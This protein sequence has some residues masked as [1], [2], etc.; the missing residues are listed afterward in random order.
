MP[1]IQ[2]HVYGLVVIAAQRQQCGAAAKVL[3]MHL[4]LPKTMRCKSLYGSCNIAVLP[5]CGVSVVKWHKM[6]L[7]SINSQCI[8]FF[9]L[10]LC[11]CFNCATVLLKNTEILQALCYFTLQ[12]CF[13]FI[14][15]HFVFF[16]F[17]QYLFIVHPAAP[18]GMLH[19]H[20]HTQIY[21]YVC[22]HW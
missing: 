4:L 22:I 20:S 12:D 3:F 5:L 11:C 18:A 9:V 15:F 19:T 7:K 1:H 16:F 13:S 17:A 2:T 14:Y 6:Y 21:V 10:Y 8:L